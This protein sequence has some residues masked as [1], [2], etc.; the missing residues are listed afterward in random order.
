MLGAAAVGSVAGSRAWASICR[1]DPGL[2]QLAT[3]ALRDLEASVQVVSADQAELAKINRDFGLAYRLKNLRMRYKEPSKLRMEGPIGSIII[4][5]SARLFKVP[6]IKLQKRDDL[7]ASPGKR[8]TLMDVGLLTADSL[9]AVQ[10]K[11]VKEETVG[12]AQTRQFELTYK[13]DD[14]VRY[15]VWIDPARHLI[16]KRE[17]YD[18][19]GKKKATF[20]FKEPKQVAD[21][22]WVPSRIEIR[23]AEDVVAAVTAYSDIKVNQ[24]LDDAL[25][26]IS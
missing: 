5:G 23:N 24:G 3:R 18:G 7:G 25:F 4:N 11:F 19:A 22:I 26:T 10:G 20:L 12:E 16:S 2:A 8:Y 13:D 17:W 6:A 1:E 14:S 21:G 9:L 15:M